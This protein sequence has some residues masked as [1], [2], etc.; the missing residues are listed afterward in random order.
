M[1]YEARRLGVDCDSERKSYPTRVR[2]PEIISDMRRVKITEKRHTG[3]K[4][5]FDF[6]S[7]L[8]LAEIGVALGGAE[9]AFRFAALLFG[10]PDADLVSVGVTLKGLAATVT[11][12]LNDPVVA[13][14][15]VA[16]CHGAAFGR[17]VFLFGA[18]LPQ[19]F[20]AT[21]LAKGGFG[22]WLFGAFRGWDIEF[23]DNLSD[24]FARE[25]DLF[26]DGFERHPLKSKIAYLLVAICF[27]RFLFRCRHDNPLLLVVRY[28]RWIKNSPSSFSVVVE[29]QSTT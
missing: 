21:G 28:R 15:F 10:E 25:V 8:A 24:A 3:G 12:E 20:L 27:G 2:A 18:T 19:E 22:G 5:A 16:L 23:F 1:K 17:A 9:I 6:G 11:N 26:S 14:G 29:D 13:V 7:G 4:S